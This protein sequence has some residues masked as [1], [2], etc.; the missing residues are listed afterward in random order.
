MGPFFCRLF[1]FLYA[2]F[3]I[4]YFGYL[5]Y[6]LHLL[7]IVYGDAE[8]NP[9]P[10][11]RWFGFSIPPFVVFTPD[12]DVLVCAQSKVCNR[13]HLSELRIPGFGCPQQRLRNSSPGAQ[14]MLF[15]LGYDSAPSGRASSCVFL[16]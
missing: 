4:Y 7:I 8:S 2:I 3:K 11:K 16:P 14:V 1:F 10:V 6:W 9:G 15:M 13:R 12:Y 5:F